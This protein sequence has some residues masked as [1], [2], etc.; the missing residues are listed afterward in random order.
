MPT[1]KGSVR[2]DNIFALSETL[3]AAFQYTFNRLSAVDNPKLMSSRDQ[4]KSSSSV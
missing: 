1:L 4:C 3:N 2:S